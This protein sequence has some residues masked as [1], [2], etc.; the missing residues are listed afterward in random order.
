MNKKDL[1]NNLNRLQKGLPSDLVY[2]NR[3]IDN[4]HVQVPNEY[5]VSTLDEFLEKDIQMVLSVGGS[6]IR[7]ILG[8]FGSGK[9]TILNRIEKILPRI[10]SI[11]KYLLVRVDLENVPVVRHQEFIKVLMKQI[12]PVLETEI[13]K[14]MYLESTE[15]DLIDIFQGYEILKNIKDLFSSSQRDR[16]ESKSY[17]FDQIE[18]QKIFQVI[19]GVI[20]LAEKFGKIVI[21]LIDELES[22]IRSDN[23]GILTDIMVSRFLRGIIDR[24]DT[25]VYIVFTCYKDSYDTLKDNFFKFYRVVEGNE[26]KISDLSDPEKKELTQKL[27]D[28]TMEYTFGKINVNSVLSKI[29]STLDFYISN[30]IKLISREILQSIDQFKEI[31]KQ[32]QEI[33]EN[34]A[35]DEIA[36]PQ[37]LKWGF[38]R[39][40][41][42]KKPEEIA[43]YNFDIFA[44][45]SERNTILQRVFGEI[46]SVTCNKGWAED[47]ITWIDM[48]IYTKSRE[49]NRNR[50]KLLFIAPDYTSEAKRLLEEHDIL[51]IEY[52][53]RAVDNILNSLADDKIKDLSDEEKAVIK[54]ISQTKT[55]CRTYGAMTRKFS[56]K[57]LE[58]L[59]N[60]KKIRIKPGKKTKSFCLI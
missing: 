37:M 41:I 30:V 17:F 7:P 47:F 3:V 29:K 52:H 20:Q 15:E 38:K 60:K 54:F 53:N 23:S 6:I 58:S 36:I 42:F 28:E 13:F 22:L 4:I 57:I 32:I 12:F 43:G 5:T 33:Y 48:Q 26:I 16:I 31:S 59:V 21:I 2:I 44:S 14:N 49:F 34:D 11:D 18:E 45:Q 56:V 51:C 35:R 9:S 50:D 39:V 25:S 55:K 24:R 8:M 10:V 40:N 27:L 46:K 1:L 19:E